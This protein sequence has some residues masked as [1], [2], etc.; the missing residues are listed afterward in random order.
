MIRFDCVSFTY[1]EST[2]PILHQLSLEIPEGELCVVV[3]ETGSGKTTLLRCINGLVPHFSGGTLS[4][5]VTVDGR[6]TREQ[7]PRAWPTSSDSSARIPWPA[8]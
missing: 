6:S 4:G 1:P 7:R 3:G 8:S 2:D 5:T